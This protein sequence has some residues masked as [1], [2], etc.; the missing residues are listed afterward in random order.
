MSWYRRLS[1]VLR[2]GRMQRDL[3]R[4]LRFHIAE[5]AEEL[6]AGGMSE[7]EAWNCAR[8]QFGNYTAQVENTRDQDT[9][10]WLDAFA[11]NLRLAVRALR[12]APAFTAAVVATLALGIGA[13]SAVFSAIYAILLRPLP[14]PAADRLVKAL[15]DH[16]KGVV[17]RVDQPKP[18]NRENVVEEKL[19][20]E[21]TF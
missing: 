17:L 9:S 7:S 18:P 12:R 11:R 10:A 6:Q 14:F 8:R 19:Y 16:A 1:N 15:N 3:E 20:F 2:P 4:E 13:N 5:R 21:V